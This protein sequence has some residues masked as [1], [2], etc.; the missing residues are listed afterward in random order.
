M[1]SY[2]WPDYN[3]PNSSPW[4]YDAATGPYATYPTTAPSGFTGHTWPY[5][6]WQASGPGSAPPPKY[7]YYA[8]A[9]PPPAGSWHTP[10]SQP[11]ASTEPRATPPYSMRPNVPGAERTTETFRMRAECSSSQPRPDGSPQADWSRW[12]PGTYTRRPVADTLPTDS[13]PGGGTQ[14]GF[15][16]GTWFVPGYDPTLDPRRPPPS[17]GDPLPEQRTSKSRYPEGKQRRSGTP[18]TRGP[19][20]RDDSSQQRRQWEE[21]KQKQW[22]QWESSML[23]QIS[24]QL[25]SVFAPA[26]KQ[27]FVALQGPYDKAGEDPTSLDAAWRPRIHEWYNQLGASMEAYRLWFKPRDPFRAHKTQ[28]GLTV[29]EQ[30]FEVLGRRK[31]DDSTRRKTSRTLLTPAPLTL[32]ALYTPDGV[33]INAYHSASSRNAPRRSSSQPGFKTESG[34]NGINFT[35]YKNFPRKGSRFPGGPERRV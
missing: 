16:C 7:S 2:N 25:P 19:S 33:E 29:V 9:P 11:R 15:G 35:A 10:N 21:W 14:Q 28:H 13:P 5:G 34:T 18:P 23:E 1:S 26:V 32:Q 17:A 31:E 30:D 24:A 6:T 12:P 22:E 27:G 20:T 3:Y 4:R 8:P